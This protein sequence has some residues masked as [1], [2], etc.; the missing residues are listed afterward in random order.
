MSDSPVPVFPLPLVL[1]PGL[2]VPLHVFE[3]RYRQLLQDV[4]G[5]DGRF[6]IVLV[7]PDGDDADAAR[8]HTVGCMARITSL[9]PLGDGRSAIVVEG[10]ERVRL[11]DW[12]DET[13]PYA[14]AT[15]QVIDEDA[16]NEHLA[17]RVRER[18]D[19]YVAALFQLVRSPAPAIPDDVDARALSYWVAGSMHLEAAEKQHLLRCPTTDERLAVLM[20]LLARE[21]SQ[22][23]AF[24][25][26]AKQQ[27]KLFFGGVPFSVN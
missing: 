21:L 1:Y 15:V 25:D 17:Q 27:G 9:D 23:A 11:L 19:E 18:F 5:V 10:E 24:A 12:D 13:R 2:S 26:M 6:A 22:V 3:P 20:Q 8:L 4:G 7:E 14:T 16:G